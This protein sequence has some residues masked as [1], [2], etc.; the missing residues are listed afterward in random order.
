MSDF[1]EIVEDEDISSLISPVRVD[2]VK[3][4]CRITNNLDN[5]ILEGLCLASTLG[6]QA[7][8][9]RVFI[10]KKFMGYFQNV[11]Y[12]RYEPYPYIVIKR[13]P[14]ISDANILS[15]VMTIDGVDTTLTKD[16]QYLIKRNTGFTR[17]WFNDTIDYDRTLPYPIKV[18]FIAGYGVEEI[19]PDDIKTAIKAYSAYMY[20]N[21][22]D[23]ETSKTRLIPDD[24]K[25]YLAPSRRI[26]ETCA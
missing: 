1:Y 23:I 19:V 11:K 14:I 4:W 17:I 12:S 9:N 13:S 5:A 7:Y 16:T 24:V 15:V 8:C 10:E 6:L 2:E 3:A 20:E 25:R 26:M 22:G 18:S 21:R